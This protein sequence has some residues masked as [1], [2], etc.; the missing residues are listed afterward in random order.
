MIIGGGILCAAYLVGGIPTGLLVGRLF[1]GI[2]VRE[3]GSG[4]LGATNVAR[5]AGKV[6]GILVLVID[7]AKGW[8]PVTLLY[9]LWPVSGMSAAPKIQI[10]LGL[11]AVAGH[12]WNP[13]LQFR[14][15]KGVATSL[16]VLLGLDPRVAVGVFL[17]WLAVA[18]TTRYVSAAS[19]SAAMAAP[20]LMAFLGLPT[21]W[22]LGG[23]GISMAV[24]ARHREN[25]L[26]LLQGEEHRFGG[27]RGWQR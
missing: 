18:L 12:I 7:A 22:I 13:F 17:I 9:S 25:L 6:P 8:L 24:V 16:G 15:G 11:L 26:R 4:N 19:V 3:H 10:L 5:V 21:S 23:I 27:S 14:G 2:D 20:F 1:R